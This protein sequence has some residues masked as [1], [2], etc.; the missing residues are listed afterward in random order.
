MVLSDE[1]VIKFQTLYMNELGIE[2]NR[3]DA[4]EK[5]IKLLQLMSNVY[6]PMTESEYA[7]IEKHREDTVHLFKNRLD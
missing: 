1:D 5:G 7:T 2:I 6:R 4:Y 3:K